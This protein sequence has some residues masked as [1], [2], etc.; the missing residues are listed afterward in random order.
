MST[1]RMTVRE[2]LQYVADYPQPVDDEIIVM[3]TSELVAR[4]LYDIANKPDAQVK[5]SMTRANKARKMILNRLA[6]RRRAGTAPALPTTN[7][8]IIRDLMGE[9]D[10]GDGA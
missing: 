8:I 3:P 4:T 5:G 1:R 2:A 9:V 6:G 7:R 10:S